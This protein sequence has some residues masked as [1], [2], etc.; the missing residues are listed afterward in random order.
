MGLKLL[1]G[2]PVLGTTGHLQSS[3][4]RLQTPLATG[5]HNVC[6]QQ[7]QDDMS[8]SR[9]VDKDWEFVSKGTE[10]SLGRFV[11]EHF[12]S[13]TLDIKTGVISDEETEEIWEAVKEV[14]ME[15]VRRNKNRSSGGDSILID[16][17]EVEKSFWLSRPH[18]W[19]VNR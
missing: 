7:V 5:V 6:F 4:C 11:S 1:G 17:E 10:I 9:S 2:R 8:K 16:E 3:V 18:G 14:A 19:V 12:T 15:K 13:L